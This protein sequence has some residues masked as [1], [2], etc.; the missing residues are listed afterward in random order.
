MSTTIYYFS[1]SGNSLYAARELRQRLPDADLVPMVRL[2]GAERIESRGE[3][4]GFVFPIHGMTLPIPVRRFISRLDPSSAH[5]LFAVATRAATPHRAFSEIDRMLRKRGRRL[6]AFFTLTMPS[7]DPKFRD[8]RPP[9]DEGLARLASDLRPRLDAIAEVVVRRQEN[10]A[11]DTEFLVPVNPL[12]ERLVLLGMAFAER[13]GAKDY[14]YANERCTGCGTCAK[15]CPSGKVR[16]DGKRPVW[17]DEV[18]CYLCYA[19]L[20]Y[21]PARAAQ[22]RSKVWMRSYTE[23][24]ERYPH[25]YATADE[26]ATQK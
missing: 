7:N 19:C 10:R 26:I 1:G 13:D 12:L 22:I 25:P 9:A 24:N 5:Y 2:L 23:Q 21:C 16:M 17:R 6:D 20:N 18:T 14:F 3:T 4:V 8:W 11:P 15:V